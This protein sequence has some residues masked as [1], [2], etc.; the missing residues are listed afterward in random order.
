MMK[1]VVSDLN[2][3]NRADY[4]VEDFINLDWD[5][6]LEALGGDYSAEQVK[7]VDMVGV[8]GLDLSLQPGDLATE[9]QV[10]DLQEELKE[11]IMQVEDFLIPDWV[12]DYFDNDISELL[13]FNKKVKDY[14]GYDLNDEL[15]FYEN[16]EEAKD[17]LY[18]VLLPDELT[19]ALHNTRLASYFDY[20]GLWE[21]IHVEFDLASSNIDG[22]F[23][24][25]PF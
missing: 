3:I 5:D 12:R 21:N 22:I 24:V 2:I 14:F 13:S 19:T 9:P 16:E 11:L 23:V 10:F 17:A 1:I 15:Q 18:Y 4:D 8:E 7:I 25:E 20:D 6:M